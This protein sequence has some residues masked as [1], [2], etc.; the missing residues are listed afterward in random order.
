MFFCK[1]LSQNHFVAKLQTFLFPSKQSVRNLLKNAWNKWKD[2]CWPPSLSAVVWSSS[3][4]V[5]RT[6]KTMATC[7]AASTRACAAYCDWKR[8]S[9]DSDFCT[10]DELKRV[11]WFGNP[12][13]TSCP[14]S[15]FPPNSPHTTSEM[16]T[17]IR[18]RVTAPHPRPAA[19]L[20]YC[21][22]TH[23]YRA[24]RQGYW[25]DRKNRSKK[26]NVTIWTVTNFS[27]K[28]LIFL[29]KKFGELRNFSYLCNVNDE[30]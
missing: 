8:K 25:C 5:R 23:P 14:L 9:E 30:G 29:A 2:G 4:R 1:C 26:R 12:L 28:I 13:F 21:A 16:K 6:M 24:I 7:P 19:T 17:S 11:P 22:I 15:Y 27:Q 20:P 10:T 18:T 3:L